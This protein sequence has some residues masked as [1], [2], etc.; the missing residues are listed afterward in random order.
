LPDEV[1]AAVLDELKELGE[2]GWA[3]AVIVAARTPP[4]TIPAASSPAARPH[5]RLRRPGGEVSSIRSSFLSVT[6]GCVVPGHPS[7]GACGEQEM[8]L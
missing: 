8:N 1:V 5:R 4:A 6:P 7:G 2:L 3:P